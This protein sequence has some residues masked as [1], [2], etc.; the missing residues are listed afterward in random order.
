MLDQENI[1]VM[2]GMR[3]HHRGLAGLSGHLQ[4]ALSSTAGRHLQQGGLL[5][6]SWHALGT[7]LLH[8]LP[9]GDETEKSYIVFFLTMRQVFH[10]ELSGLLTRQCET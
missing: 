1:A 3:L 4:A 7:D 8:V 5:R 2:Y 10:Q 6:R 9:V